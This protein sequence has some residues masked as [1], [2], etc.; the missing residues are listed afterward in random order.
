MVLALTDISI[1]KLI[2]LLLP[3]YGTTAAIIPYTFQ[4]HP[5]GYQN[6]I[7]KAEDWA[8]NYENSLNLHSINVYQN[9]DHL[10]QGYV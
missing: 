1:D 8:V 3:F 10:Y 5:D 7:Q 2:P 9:W 4:V 6:Y